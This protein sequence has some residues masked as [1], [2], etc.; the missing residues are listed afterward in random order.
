MKTGSRFPHPHTPIHN[1]PPP[2][3]QLSPMSFLIQ[4]PG[5]PLRTHFFYASPLPLDDPLSA[6]PIPTGDSKSA[7]HPPRP[8]S[9]RDNNAL[10]EI[11]LRFSAGHKT[12]TRHDKL[13]KGTNTR[14]E[15]LTSTSGGPACCDHFERGV[16]G[17]S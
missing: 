6:I 7:K 12:H 5:I 14:K 4:T 13:G 10:E 15:T 11:W 9:A 17:D 16:G 1:A 8:F 3:H 2:I